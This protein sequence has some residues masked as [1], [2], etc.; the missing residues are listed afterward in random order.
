MADRQRREGTA[1]HDPGTDRA[2]ATG[3]SA[4]MNAAIE[5][6]ATELA[7]DR[8][9][10][11]AELLSAAADLSAG[12]IEPA[13]VVAVLEP[14]ADLSTA[15]GEPPSTCGDYVL[16]VNAV[17]GASAAET[18]SQTR[19][20]IVTGGLTF[21]DCRAVLRYVPAGGADPR[22]RVKEVLED[23]FEGKRRGY[24]GERL[25]QYVRGK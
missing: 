10:E 15:T 8:A 12:G 25:A 24:S 3:F 19:R 6:A 4:P 18:A 1:D 21:A 20:A 11:R 17:W 13:A 5:A 9:F 23:A 22:Q 14:I 16:Q 7:A 2:D